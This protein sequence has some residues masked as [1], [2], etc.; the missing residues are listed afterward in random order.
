MTQTSELGQYRHCLSLDK[1]ILLWVGD[2]E[3]EVTQTM[4]QLGKSRHC[5]TLG[6]LILLWVER[7]DVT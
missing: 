7:E 3:G 6:N 5:P 1:S 2:G 4:S